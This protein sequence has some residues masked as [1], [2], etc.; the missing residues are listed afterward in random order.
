L[1]HCEGG[2]HGDEEA[3]IVGDGEA[4]EGWKRIG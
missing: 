1:R 4:V 3:R 2:G